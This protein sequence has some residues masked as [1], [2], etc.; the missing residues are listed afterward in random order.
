[1]SR[2]LESTEI[3]ERVYAQE[4]LPEHICLAEESYAQSSARIHSQDNQMLIAKGELIGW[5]CV[6]LEE[7]NRTLGAAFDRNVVCHRDGALW[8]W[9]DCSVHCKRRGPNL[10]GKEALQLQLLK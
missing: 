1:M 9:K 8:A 2:W 5:T 6:L 3:A 4:D 10:K 7:A